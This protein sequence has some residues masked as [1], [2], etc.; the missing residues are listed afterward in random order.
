[1]RTEVSIFSD[2]KNTQLKETVVLSAD[3]SLQFLDTLRVILEKEPTPGD[4]IAH[5][6]LEAIL[7][8]DDARAA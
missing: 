6:R 7:E 1:M 4:G 5:Y 8:D 2:I 3:L